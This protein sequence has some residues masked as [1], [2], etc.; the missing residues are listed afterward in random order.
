[1]EVAQH[2]ADLCLP[3]LGRREGHVELGR[4]HAS[5]ARGGG[6]PIARL[7]E[8]DRGVVAGV[9]ALG[10]RV[11]DEA[12]GYVRPKGKPDHAMGGQCHGRKHV[13]ATN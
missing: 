1:V 5:G 2:V 6:V 8:R 9:A 7:V 13:R 12:H 3:R 10:G 4:N 11:E